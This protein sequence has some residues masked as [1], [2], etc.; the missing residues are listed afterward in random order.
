MKAHEEEWARDK[1]GNN[2][3]TP[4]GTVATVHGEDEGHVVQ[5]MRLI[6]A[7]PDLVRVLLWQGMTRRLA[8]G[9][10]PQWHTFECLRRN[11]LSGCTQEC[12]VARGALRKAGVIP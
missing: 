1:R 2:I 7:A 9:D 10:E 12:A 11:P 6:A 4:D 8:S 5:R 3:S